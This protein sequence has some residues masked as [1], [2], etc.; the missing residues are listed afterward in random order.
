MMIRHYDEP[1]MR[2]VLVSDLICPL[3]LFL[4]HVLT[5]SLYCPSRFT[6]REEVSNEYLYARNYSHIPTSSFKET[7]T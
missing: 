5:A 4:S 6:V 3:V 1:Q 7:E 2:N